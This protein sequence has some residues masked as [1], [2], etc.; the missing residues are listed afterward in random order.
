MC[1]LDNSSICAFLPD[2]D[3]CKSYVYVIFFTASKIRNASNTS[4]RVSGS[5]EAYF[6]NNFDDWWNLLFVRIR[7]L[8]SADFLRVVKA[9]HFYDMSVVREQNRYIKDKYVCT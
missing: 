8:F 9:R 1:F 3:I 5:R 2:F 7:D 4:F 6:E